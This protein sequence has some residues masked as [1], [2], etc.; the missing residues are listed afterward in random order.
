MND[1]HTESG[2]RQAGRRRLLC[3][4][5]SLVSLASQAA[6]LCAGLAAQARQLPDTAWRGADPLSK[7]IRRVVSTGAPQT[8]LEESLSQDPRWQ[9]QLPESNTAVTRLPGTDV[10]LL[11]QVAGTAACQSYVLAEAAPGRPVRQLPTPIPSED[12]TDLCLTRSAFVAMVFGRP[13]LVVGGQEAMTGH[14][15]RYRI[16]TWDGQRWEAPCG[17]MIKLRTRLDLTEQHC[18]ADAAWC[19]ASARLAQEM[20]QAYDVDR[21]GGAKLD[22]S[23]FAQGLSPDAEVTHALSSPDRG[24]G[25]FG[26]ESLELPLLGDTPVGRNVFLDAYSNADQRRLP[27]RIAGRWWLVA[28]SRAGVGWRE[29]NDTLLTFYA[30]PGRAADAVASFRLSL[31]PAG[32]SSATVTP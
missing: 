20:V 22:V 15:S 28:M 4:T 18:R 17:L 12:P 13:A 2:W 31:Q 19:G 26:S 14:D 11:E 3:A 1:T 9:E 10:Y 16:S 29:S 23:R 25:A 30:P 5:L 27:V 24:A 8:A 32:L 7:W 6:P 21:Q